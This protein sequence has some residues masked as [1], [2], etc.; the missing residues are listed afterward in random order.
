MSECDHFRDLLK[1]LLV[2]EVTSS[3]EETLRRHAVECRACGEL[4]ELHQELAAIAE[5]APEPAEEELRAMREGVLEEIAFRDRA[6]GLPEEG[7]APR[8]TWGFLRNLHPVGALAAAL[9]V[10]LAAFFFGRSMGKPCEFDDDL[11]MAEIERQASV[12]RGL[13]GYWDTPFVYSNVSVNSL[14]DGRVELG[15]DVA[16]HVELVT[17]EDSPVAKQI[18][19]HAI[20]DPSEIEFPFESAAYFQDLESGESIPVVP[21]T[22]RDQYLEL[23]NE[24]VT[25]LEQRLVRSRIDYARFNTSLPLDFAL[26][27]YLARR[28]RM[29]RVR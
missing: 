15:F 17:P 21:E 2:G 7:A 4:L 8:R 20:L 19:L 29:S 6:R 27:E 26:F 13:A 22:L 23:M 3:E 18:L 16:R 10:A 5:E 25:T 11:L 24:H 9:L 14:N 1:R 12:Q 28:H